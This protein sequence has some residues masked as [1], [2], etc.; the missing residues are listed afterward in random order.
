[1]QLT[2]SGRYVGCGAPAASG[3]PAA[4]S[5]AWQL[6]EAR[7]QKCSTYNTMSRTFLESFR[8]ASG[9]ADH[10]HALR[11]LLG[12][13]RDG[14]IGPREREI[15][16]SAIA[17]ALSDHHSAWRAVFPSL[18]RSPVVTSTVWEMTLRGKKDAYLRKLIVSAL[19]G[20]RAEAGPVINPVAD[21]GKHARALARDLPARK[22]LATDIDANLNRFYSILYRITH[23]AQRNYTFAR[24]SI[25][26]PTYGRSPSAVVFFGACGSL[27]DAAMD[28]AIAETAPLLMCR[29]CC[30]EN[31][32]CCTDLARY[33]TWLNFFFWIKN[34]A[35]E[36]YK[37]R[38]RGCYFSSNYG[39]DA[40]PRSA[41]ASAVSS[42][43][44]LHEVA[45]NTLES[46]ICRSIIDL[47]RCLRLRESG[48]DVLY[49]RG[50]F[51]GIS[52]RLVVE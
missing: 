45:R 47:D 40:Y 22:V 41:T 44:E 34:R 30:H 32:G 35:F 50:I 43:K 23:R 27:M 7:L 18:P 10:E 20:L 1:M 3:K 12:F 37:A 2:R 29:A 33:P 8:S 14:K 46:N 11:I 21:F 24:E 31:I 49:E 36:I 13:F 4:E 48:Y 38:N 9:K 19:Q 5:K 17:A 6:G 25:F 39:Q 26:S 28:Y 51:Y 52:R 16:E 15:E 42:P